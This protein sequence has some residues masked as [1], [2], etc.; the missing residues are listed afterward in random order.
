[1]VL[2]GY[3]RRVGA[4]LSPAQV[5]DPAVVA[6]G[7]P[8]EIAAACLAGVDTG[9]AERAREGDVL[10]IDGA[11]GGGA[12]A[13]AAVIALQAVGFAAVVC[14]AA[15]DEPRAR[16]EAYGLPVLASTAAGAIGEGDLVRIDLE[17]G[18]IEARGAA[19]DAPPLD[20]QALA[21]VRRGQLLSRMRRV[22]EDEGYA[23]G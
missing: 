13:E 3:A 17:R 18:R 9:I 11:L 16:G 4:D 23:D 14:R 22:V 20:P 19:W 5:V 7:D 12:G 10:V 8:A 6:E 1:M 2:T 21:A 15:D